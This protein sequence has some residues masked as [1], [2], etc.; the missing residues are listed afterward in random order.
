MADADDEHVA[1]VGTGAVDGEGRGR[2]KAGRHAEAGLHQ[3]LGEDGGVVGGAAGDEKDEPRLAPLH[4]RRHLVDGALPVAEDASQRK[5]LLRDVCLHDLAEHLSPSLISVRPT[6]RAAC[7]RTLAH[8]T[9]WQ[10]NGPADDSTGPLVERRSAGVSPASP[11]SRCSSSRPRS[12]RGR[13][14]PPRARW[15]SRFCRQRG[16][17]AEPRRRR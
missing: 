17:P 7:A 3:V 13:C 12:R 10:P 1:Q 16:S 11:S 14:C 4:G 2:G 15:R 9:V 8:S 6:D 5:W